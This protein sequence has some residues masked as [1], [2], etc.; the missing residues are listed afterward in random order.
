MHY[1]PAETPCHLFH[2]PGETLQS[3]FSRAR[4]IGSFINKYLLFEADESLLLV[5]QHAAQERIMFEKFKNQ[6]DEGTVEVQNLL[7]PILIKLT[8][9]ERLTWEES[10]EELK[11]AGLD[12]TQFDGQ[13]LA[14]HT[15]PVLI[16]NPEMAL[17]A[18]LAENSITRCDHATIARRA[19]RASVMTGD[20]MNPQQ[21]VHQR[22]QLL[23]CENPFTC[24]HGRPTV[25]EITDRFLEK[26][27][28]RS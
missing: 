6:I 16:K 2:S 19:C 3:K 5:D 8:A 7:T 12:T 22:D 21:A 28:L 4:H 14:L 10:Q 25:V 11:K 13:T 27:F 23:A 18:L 24:P 15:H 9:Q 1:A 20:K 17:R 26:Q